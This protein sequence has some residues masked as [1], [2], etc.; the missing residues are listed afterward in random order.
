MA[1]SN[2]I[3]TIHQS[4][5]TLLTEETEARI[6]ILDQDFRIRGVTSSGARFLGFVR[7]N[8]VGTSGYDV[9]PRE[10][11]EERRRLNDQVIQ[12]RSPATLV[13]TL[14]GWRCRTRVCY[15]GQDD[16]GKHLVAVVINPQ[17]LQT[18][19]DDGVPSGEVMHVRSADGA[20][21]A[22]LSKAEVR[23][24]TM[25]G[26]GLST[27]DM[28]ERTGRSVKT[29]EGHRFAIGRKLGANNRVEL[30][31]IAIRAGLAS[32]ELRPDESVRVLEKQ[33]P[34]PGGAP[35]AHN[36]SAKRRPHRKKS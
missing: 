14:R 28:A 35:P 18:L 13:E 23:V 21:L 34:A 25:I 24:L 2:S 7:D 12:S 22:R 10:Y 16:R 32:L 6:V 20:A 19:D 3:P 8:V 17:A 5:Y 30:A 29:I 36:G 31:R 15:F 4:W 1:G 33:W 27:S 26:E 11:A 9:M